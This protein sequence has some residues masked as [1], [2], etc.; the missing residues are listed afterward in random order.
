MTKEELKQL[1]QEELKTIAVE[2]SKVI[3]QY[4]DENTIS[5]EQVE[6]LEKANKL[7]ESL[8]GLFDSNEDGA[9]TLDEFVKKLNEIYATLSNVKE[10]KEQIL[11][12]AKDL[13]A[14]IERVDALEKNLSENYFTK[15]EAE[16][17][18]TFDTDSIVS[19]VRAV[20]FPETIEDSDGA[21]E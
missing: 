9:I 17:I 13:G 18:F 2:T 7:A 12:I 1:T 6:E 4:I 16:E 21:V 14:L 10:L 5:P 19:E 11:S 8:L 20:F 15:A 3:K